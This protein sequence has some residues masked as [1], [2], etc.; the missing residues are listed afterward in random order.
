MY[1]AKQVWSF[2]NIGMCRKQKMGISQKEGMLCTM[3]LQIR[4]HHIIGYIEY[5]R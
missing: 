5:Y 3:I 4:I 1:P 2:S